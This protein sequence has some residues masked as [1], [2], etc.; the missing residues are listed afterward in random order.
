[1]KW[2]KPAYLKHLSHIALMLLFILHTPTVFAEIKTITTL[3][4][5]VYTDDNYD[6]LVLASS[7]MS[8]TGRAI[9][10]AR[11]VHDVYLDL[12]QDTILWNT[13]GAINTWGIEIMN[14]NV[15]NITVNGGY[16]LHSPPAS[17][18][19]I[20]VVLRA[21]AIGLGGRV[22]DIKIQ[23][24]YLEVYGRN[25]QIIY[26]GNGCY[27]IEIFN[28]LFNDQ[29]TAFTQRD[30]WIDNAMLALGNNDS[31]SGANFDYHFK[32]HACSTLNAHWVNLYIQ[33]QALVAEIF[34]NFFIS[35]ARNDVPNSGIIYGTAAQC[36]AVSIRGRDSG[37]RVKF[38]NNTIR[39]GTNHAG[40]R[41]IFISGID[42]VSLHPDS[43]IY[44]YN[45]DIFVH[46]GYDEE[47]TTLNGILVRQG[48]KNI[49]IRE[50][51]IVCIGDTD[52]STSY[53]DHGPIS[54]MRLTGPGDGLKIV[55]NTIKTYFV[56]EFTP[57]YSVSGTFAGAIVFDE[58]DMNLPNIII[59]SN[60]FESNSLLIRW[61]FFNGHGG[62]V[63]MRDNTYSFYNNQGDYVFYLGYGAGGSHHAYNNKI[64]DGHYINN[65]TSTN[66]FMDD[67]EPDSLSIALA[68]VVSVRVVD[69]LN[70]VQSNVQVSIINA[71]GDTVA[72]GLTNQN[73]IFESLITY[74][75][76]ANDT[77]SE[78]DSLNF[79]NFD[80]I[81]RYGQDIKVRNYH[82]DENSFNPT[83]I[84]NGE[85]VSDDIPPARI[86]DLHVTPGG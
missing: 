75:W 62:N 86:N 66:I 29:M 68:R 25:S 45:N 12:G 74:W 1:M 59:D 32:I 18:L 33:G 51:R 85:Q 21:R 40:G 67:A 23:N 49:Y 81:A 3:P 22:H 15:Y 48:W 19:D 6:T 8:A 64:I 52:P 11:D 2:E 17:A 72:N 5:T 78:E 42:G 57:N 82:I 44:I 79:N 7:K 16:I 55:G 65:A 61:G 56:D 39:S 83:L 53:I 26:G 35:D 80:I 27:N 70:D 41:G 14:T 28:C 38:Y 4:Y 43:S 13:S 30:M 54:G 50:N 60:L 69:T 37:S 73:G 84:I 63:S 47:E 24:C 46:Q 36:Y 34:D 71:Y 76:E 9:S 10:F 20:N 77:F 31:Q 58:F